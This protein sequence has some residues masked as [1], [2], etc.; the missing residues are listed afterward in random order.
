MESMRWRILY[1]VA[2][3]SKRRSSRLFLPNNAAPSPLSLHPVR[4]AHGWA[5]QCQCASSLAGETWTVTT[6]PFRMIYSSRNP[7]AMLRVSKKTAG[8]GNAMTTGLDVTSAGSR[9]GG[10]PPAA[11]ALRLY[12]SMVLIRRVEERLRD[13]SAAGKL[14]GAV[15]LY[16]GEEAVAAGV[17]AHLEDRDYA[18]STHRGHGHFLAKGGDV[19]AMM[20]EIWAKR[21][22]ICQGMGGSMHVADLARGILGANGIVGAGLS[23]AAGAAFGAKLD[24][25]GKASV[26]F[27]GDGASNQGVLMETLNVSA[28]W[29]L[30]LVFVCENN[31]FSE[32]TP[33]AEVT[34][35]RIADRARAFSLP[36]VEVDGNDVTEVWRA[37][38]EAVARARGGG[39]PSF[40]EARTYRI[41]G[42]FEAE[43]F[44][45][46]NGRY[47]DN[48]EIHKRRGHAPSRLPRAG[49]RRAARGGARG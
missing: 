25:D 15:H 3:L 31:G 29:R 27:F 35:G 36:A 21:E 9:P 45:L 7:G 11:E 37:A 34:A 47:R 42:H 48:E 22:G 6:S 44:V 33:A 46:G 13:D 19:R 8:G 39:G 4:H 10:G 16:I 12:E 14:P 20:A 17:C 26:C 41:Q 5:W 43:S 49:L 32:F 30:P 40:I 2:T 24:G 28:L 23:I 1:R 38:G 18:T